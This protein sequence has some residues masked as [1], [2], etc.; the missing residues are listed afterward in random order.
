QTKKN[1][2]ERWKN[3]IEIF[4]VTNRSVFDSKHILLI[5]D[6][7]TTGA[8]LEACALELL[9]SKNVKISIATMAFTE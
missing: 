9:K 2:F 4:D 1:R 5:D 3:V 6:V 8:T 7:L